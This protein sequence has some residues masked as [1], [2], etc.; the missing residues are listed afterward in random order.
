MLT[1][2]KPI[3]DRTT[4]C[5][6]DFSCLSGPL[7]SICKITRR[8]AGDVFIIQC[9]EKSTCKYCECFGSWSICTCPIRME[10]YKRHGI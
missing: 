7:D 10:L 8:I 4:R 5:Q 3:Q 1:V 9:A 2:S 6:S